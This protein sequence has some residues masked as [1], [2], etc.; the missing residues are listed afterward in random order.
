MKT[1]ERG[2][3]YYST[4]PFYQ[5]PYIV[6]TELYLYAALFKNDP[7]NALATPEFLTQLIE[8]T[9]VYIK[10]IRKLENDN[11]IQNLKKD[12]GKIDAYKVVLKILNLYRRHL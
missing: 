12:V 4:K 3:E 10:N 5:S 1:H 6:F 11:E 7:E 2:I 9:D 8:T